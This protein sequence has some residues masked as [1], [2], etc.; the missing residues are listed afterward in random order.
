MVSQVN[1]E[2]TGN[3]F[4][5]GISFEIIPPRDSLF[6]YR[7][8]PVQVD[9]K[10]VWCKEEEEYC[11]VTKCEAMYEGFYIRPLGKTN[12]TVQYIVRLHLDKE[13]S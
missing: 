8:N 2:D 5:D 7:T 6:A 1:R 4:S 13:K 10:R 12:C 3:D 9:G 11:I